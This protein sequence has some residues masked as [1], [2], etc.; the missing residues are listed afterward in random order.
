MDKDEKKKQLRKIL[1]KIDVQAAIDELIEH[2]SV[3]NKK[4][5]EFDKM[6]EKEKKE[7]LDRQATMELR[8]DSMIA[9]LS[10]SSEDKAKSHKQEL[11]KTEDKF[12]QII[13]EIRGQISATYSKMG[14]GTMPQLLQIETPDFV[15]DSITKI[16]TFKH[17][18][19][20]ITVGG[21]IMING[22]GYTI[23]P[24]GASVFQVTFDNAPQAFPDGS[25]QTIHSFYY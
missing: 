2:T 17:S 18:P 1:A 10:T 6:V 16:Y 11:T 15:P 7:H 13:K 22:D 20:H 5:Q 9:K 23:S 24:L 8:Y 3:L 25:Y 14:G 12:N 19:L 4:I 21:A